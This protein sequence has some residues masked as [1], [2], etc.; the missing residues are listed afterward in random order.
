MNR[1]ATKLRTSWEDRF[2]APSVSELSAALNRP[3]EHL[4]EVAREGLLS[5]DGVQET[6]EWRGIP[7]R[8]TMAYAVD[9]R[10]LAYL[11]PQPGKPRMAI[12]L[13][14]EV[15]AAMDLRK[16]SKPVRDAIVFAPRVAEVIWPVW[17]LLNRAQIDEL[18]LVARRKHELL[19][20]LTA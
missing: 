3:Q 18:V 12:P 4:V 9:S 11:V 8:W 7:W 2:R 5:L 17:D 6:I 1:R 16:S 20:S 10:A 14:D 15:L 13:P 19:L